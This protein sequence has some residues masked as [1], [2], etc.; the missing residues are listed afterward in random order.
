MDNSRELNQMPDVICYS[1]EAL[2][3]VILSFDEILLDESVIGTDIFV[4]KNILCRAGGI[5]TRLKSKQN[6][7]LLLRVAIDGIIIKSGNRPPADNI[8]WIQLEDEDTDLVSG[9]ETDCYVVSRYHEEF[10]RMNCFDDAINSIIDVARNLGI[11]HQILVLMEKMIRKQA[12]YNYIYD[13]T[14]PILV[15]TGDDIC[16]NVLTTMAENIGAALQ[17][18]GQKVEYFNVSENNFKGLVQFVSRRF[19]AIIGVQ[20]YLFSVKKKDDSFIHDE[21]AGPKY[22]YVFDHP[23]WLR[24]FWE[25]KPQHLSALTLDGHYVKFIEKYYQTNAYFL[26]PAGEKKVFDAV[27]RIYELTFIGSYNA[28]ADL[29]IRQA[30]QYNR[31]VRLVINRFFTIMKK[32]L[33]MPPEQALRMAL[34][35]YRVQEDF[36]EMFHMLRWVILYIFNYYRRKVLERL[37]KSGIA[38]HVFGES[39]I[40]CPLRKFPNLICHDSVI[41]EESL[42]VY[43]QSKLSLNIMAWHKDGFTERIANIMLQKTVAITDKTTYLESNFI[44]GHDIVTFDLNRINELPEM[45]LE[46]LRNDEKRMLIAEN[47]YKKALKYHVWDCRMRELLSIIKKDSEKMLKREE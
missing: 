2:N 36:L 20:T 33:T 17:Q 47:G 8:T 28:G 23:I 42:R 46:L 30:Y 43:R 24:N 12:E 40:N 45:I 31:D 10:K 13:E 37:L 32:N 16:Y 19:K 6:Y 38:L 35:Y 18:L 26:P 44:S 25:T 11:Y 27:E 9:L 22:N 15:Y 21:I 34:Y 29:M 7:E 41:G 39:W 4:K 5:N 1:K 3:E 14:Q